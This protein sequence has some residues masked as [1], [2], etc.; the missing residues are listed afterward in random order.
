MGPALSEQDLGWCKDALV[1]GQTWEAK[2][3]GWSR[4]G[5]DLRSVLTPEGAVVSCIPSTKPSELLR[6]QGCGLAQGPAICC[7]TCWT[8]QHHG[9]G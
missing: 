4:A 2:G 6:L 8:L 7:K 1:A 5:R 9:P 3:H